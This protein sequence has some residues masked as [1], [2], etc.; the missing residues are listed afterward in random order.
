VRR[1]FV[2]IAATC[3]TV[4]T[5]CFGIFFVQAAWFVIHMPSLKEA[6][7]QAGSIQ[8]WGRYFLGFYVA[9][10]VILLLASERDERS[11]AEPHGA[12]DQDRGH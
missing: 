1:L 7:A 2:G 10:F 9:G 8:R 3:L 5:V 6:L 4:G 12:P 11:I